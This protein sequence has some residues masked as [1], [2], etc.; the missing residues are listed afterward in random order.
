MAD[1]AMPKLSQV[2][3]ALAVTVLATLVLGGTFAMY[4]PF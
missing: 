1:P 3:T 4:L 2:A